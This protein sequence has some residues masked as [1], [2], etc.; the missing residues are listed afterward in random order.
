[1][2]ELNSA[3]GDRSVQESVAPTIDTV[4]LEHIAE[5]LVSSDELMKVIAKRLGLPASQIVPADDLLSVF[6]I[7]SRDIVNSNN[8]KSGN[9]ALSP[10]A[11]RDPWI[12]DLHEMDYD[13]DDDLWSDDDDEAGDFDVEKEIGEPEDMPSSQEEAA[14]LR[15]KQWREQNLGKDKLTSTGPTVPF[16]HLPQ[17]EQ[18]KDLLGDGLVGSREEVFGWRKLPR[19]SFKE[20]FLRNACK[21]HTLGPEKGSSNTINS[22]VFLSVISPID[23]C[24]YVP[25]EFTTN[26]DAIFIPDAKKDMERAVATV[27]RNIR[28]EEELARNLPTDD[29]LLFGEA[30]EFT[31]VDAYLQRQLQEDQEAIV[32][33]KEAA[34]DK[35][36]LA[37]KSNNIAQMEDALAEEI[38]VNSTD[39]FGNTLLILAAQ[40]GSKRM[41]KF[42]L[43]RGANI[44]MQSLAGNTALHYCYA[45][46]QVDLAEYLKSRVSFF[47]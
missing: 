24:K 46:S 36:I 5:Q 44:N 20:G 25:P 1:M 28:R 9:R 41:C 17:N 26:I 22:A 13:S 19:P 40:Q 31:S 37:A 7:K 3:L 8:L 33:P 6:S 38:P 39:Q 2:N 10:Q 43:R 11:P 21:T 35:A 42:L 30:K 34:I 47:Y 15:R 45:Y 32:D 27:E 29:L 16:L 23:A 14:A 12:D 4:N 18:S